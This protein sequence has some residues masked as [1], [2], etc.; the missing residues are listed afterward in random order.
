MSHLVQVLEHVWS[1]TNIPNDLLS[2]L[3]PEEKNTLQSVERS[4]D[5]ESQWR[6]IALSIMNTAQNLAG[7]E[8]KSKILDALV[9]SSRRIIRSDIAYISIND[10]ERQ[11]TQVLTTSGVITEQFREVEIPLGIGVIGTVAKTKKPYWTYDQSTDPDLSRVSN[12]DRVVK[13]EGVKGILGAPLMVNGQIIGTLMV[14]D[15]RPRRYTAE[16]VIILDSL[17]SMASVALETSQLIADLE[18]NV[19]ALHHAHEKS[20]LQVSQLSAISKADSQFMDLLARRTRISTIRE[21]IKNNLGCESWFIQEGVFLENSSLEHLS[22]ERPDESFLESLTAQSQQHGDIIIENGYSVLSISFNQR[23]LGAICV[24]KEVQGMH[25]AILHR[26]AQAFVAI[27]LFREA[28]AEA[29]N[30]QLDDLLRKV[31]AGHGTVEDLLRIK[32][33]TGLD[34]SKNTT[35]YLAVFT[36]RN[37]MPALLEFQNHLPKGGIIFTYE[38]NHCVLFEAE[39]EPTQALQKLFT[40]FHIQ[41]VEVFAGAIQ[42]PLEVKNI[43]KSYNKAARLAQSMQTLRLKNQI[44][45]PTTFGTLGLLLGSNELSIEEIILDTLGPLIEHDL[46]NNSELAHTAANYFDH[47]RNIADTAK[48][49]NIHYNT[50]RQ[51]IDKISSILGP[52]W[53]TG[54]QS[55]DIHLALRARQITNTP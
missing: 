41:N 34:I 7:G 49:I 13:N 53:A 3:T 24:N 45:T 26:A 16:E 55:F 2:K 54:P 15:R 18:D 8:D 47:A 28:V 32:R 1:G 37:R 11:L 50:V 42:I 29:E 21:V 9:A 14:G 43:A 35:I 46:Q 12:V 22:K 19:V 17:A 33:L 30:R 5:S 39:T 6:D 40:Q 51:R 27:I 38:Q 10:N 23:Q 31:I 4:R 52:N 44:A 20:Q 48:A 25:A 36:S